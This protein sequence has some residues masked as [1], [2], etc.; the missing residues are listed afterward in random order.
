[1]TTTMAHKIPTDTQLRVYAL[2]I[3]EANQPDNGIQNWTAQAIKYR[4]ILINEGTSKEFLDG[5]QKATD[6]LQALDN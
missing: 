5:F 2:L 6:V 4:N 1:M 3:M